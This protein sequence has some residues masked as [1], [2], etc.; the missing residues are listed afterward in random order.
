MKFMNVAKKYASNKYAQAGAVATGL[1]VSASG[2]FAQDA[3]AI[4][5]LQ[6]A[7]TTQLSKI[8]STQIAIGI[9]LVGIAA[10]SFCILKVVSMSKGRG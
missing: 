8:S 9:I 1:M 7:V 4:T 2:A 5:Q 10:L 6:T 3:D